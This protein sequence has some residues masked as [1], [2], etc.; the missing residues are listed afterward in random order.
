MALQAYAVDFRAPGL[1]K[2]DYAEGASVLLG[3]VF[4]VVVLE[5]VRG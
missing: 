3:T 5:G 2:L 4:E 1:D